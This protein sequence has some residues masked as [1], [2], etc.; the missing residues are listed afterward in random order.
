MRGRRSGRSAIRSGAIACW[1]SRCARQIVQ[2]EAQ[3]GIPVQYSIEGEACERLSD[4]RELVLLRAAQEALHNIRKHA[5]ATQAVISLTWETEQGQVGVQI[6]DDGCG[7]GSEG[8]QQ[9][10]AGPSRGVGLAIM[11][12]RVEALGGR[13][14]I[15]SQAERGTT[16]HIV[17]P[18]ENGA[19]DS[20]H[21]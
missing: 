6:S 13:V 4:V 21:A 10:Q 9:L 5:E 14:T 19:G 12:E 2:F 17:L 8:V 1:K 15:D 18:I 16:V 3:T 20:H 7:I 11:R